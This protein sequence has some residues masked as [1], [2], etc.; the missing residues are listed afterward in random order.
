M[1]EFDGYFVDAFDT[2]LEQ[3]E[4]DIVY[5][6]RFGQCRRMKAIVDRS[7]PSTWIA[8]EVVTPSLTVRVHNDKT[9]GITHEEI[10]ILDKV[11]VAT[12]ARGKVTRQTFQRVENAD[13]EVTEIAVI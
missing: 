7:P 8:G 3:F 5:H 9:T 2:L 1:T 10:D 13:G 4:E 6:P 12:K 11:E